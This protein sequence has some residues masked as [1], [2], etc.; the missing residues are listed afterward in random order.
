MQNRKEFVFLA[1]GSAA[2]EEAVSTGI[3]ADHIVRV[4]HGDAQSYQHNVRSV[5]C[6]ISSYRQTGSADWQ[7][8]VDGDTN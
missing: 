3:V 5:A 6:N 8:K 4:K 7:H 2:F 1:A